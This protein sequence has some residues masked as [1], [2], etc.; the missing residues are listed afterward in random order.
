MFDPQIHWFS[1]VNSIVIVMILASMV[2]M[3]LLR[4]LH[5][6][7]SRY[8]SLNDEEG[9]QEEFGWKM[10]HADVFRPPSHRMLLS[11][12]LGNGAQILCMGAVTIVFAVL[13]FLSP[14]SR[15]SLVTVALV[16]YILFSVISGYCSGL[17]Y[18]TLQG[19]QW[20]LNVILTG[21]PNPNPKHSLFLV[22]SLLFY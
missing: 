22:S 9:A 13:G 18:K 10:I 3:I 21:N 14:S 1:I 20:R 16:F 8:N 11:V 17:I 4:T 15:G 6:D 5:R 7:I 12:L 19:A 2:A